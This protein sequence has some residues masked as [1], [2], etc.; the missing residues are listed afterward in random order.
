MCH[1]LC[2][3]QELISGH[4]NCIST[5]HRRIVITTSG[6]VV[7]WH[8]DSENSCRT[9]QNFMSV[10]VPLTLAS[11]KTYIQTPKSH[12]YLVP[13]HSYN[14]F[15][16]GGRH[17]EFVTPKI[18]PLDWNMLA[19]MSFSYPSRK[20]YHFLILFDIT[21]NISR[22]SDFDLIFSRKSRV[23][24]AILDSRVGIG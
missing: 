8:T 9:I 23:P 1:R 17:I 18:T 14:Y 5:S 12:F 22:I 6:F 20:S 15:R 11:S 13:T 7:A 21:T 24:V 10:D 19:V 3:A 16:F 4:R 2:H